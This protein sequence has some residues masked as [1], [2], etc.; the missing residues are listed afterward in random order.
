M[1][2]TNYRDNR[3]IFLFIIA[4]GISCYSLIWV[5][6][7]SGNRNSAYLISLKQDKITEIR[8]FDNA[9]SQKSLLT[10]LTNPKDNEIIYEFVRALN[11]AEPFEPPY[12]QLILS[13]EVYLIINLNDN[14]KSIELSF[15]LNDNCKKTVYVDIVK[16]EGSIKSE[17][18]LY[19]WLQKLDLLNYLGCD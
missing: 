7:W 8:I 4:A 9:S 3:I 18:Y 19:E 2:S 10:T 16:K 12:R 17:T 5:L 11:K 13:H 6:D 15:H 14:N 1:K